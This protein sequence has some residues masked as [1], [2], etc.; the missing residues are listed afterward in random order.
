MEREKKR[1]Q[2]SVG[3][4]A[5]NPDNLENR[6]EAGGGAQKKRGFSKNCTVQVERV[7]PLVA[8]GQRVP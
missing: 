6:K 8:F 3:S 1:R 5:V 4:V 2:E 7:Y